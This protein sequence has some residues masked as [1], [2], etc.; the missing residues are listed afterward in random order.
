MTLQRQKVQIPVAVGI[1][2]K[3]DPKQLQ[4]QLLQLQNGY[5]QRT[6]EIRKRNGFKA[7]PVVDSDG[8]AIGTAEQIVNYIGELLLINRT[9]LYTYG[10]D[11]W[12]LK[13]ECLSTEAD[14]DDVIINSYTQTIPDL[15]EIDGVAVFAWEDSRGGSRAQIVNAYTGA[16]VEADYLLNAS[17]TRPRCFA[18]GHY[19]YVFY[20]VTGTV[21]ARRADARAGQGFGSE[22]T[23][24]S[25]L[26]STTPFYDICAAGSRMFM[27]YQN[28]SN[29]LVIQYVNQDLTLGGILN[30]V[31]DPLAITAESA[32]A[33]I[34]VFSGTDSIGSMVYHVVWLNTVDGVKHMAFNADF[35]TYLA[36]VVM[37]ATTTI[38]NVTGIV[39]DGLVDVYWEIDAAIDMNNRVEYAVLTES[40]NTVT[41]AATVLQRAAGLVAKCFT[42]DGLR[43][44]VAVVFDSVSGLQNTI[45]V[46]NR[47]G[48]IEAKLLPQIAGDVTAKT[49][50][51]SNSWTFRDRWYWAAQRRTRVFADDGT[52]FISTGVVAAHVDYQSVRVGLPVSIGNTLLIPGGYVKS[53]DG[54]SVTEQNFHLY[55][56]QPTG[57]IGSAGNIADGVYLYIIVYEWIDG[58][59][60]LVRSETSVPYSMTMTGGP[61]EISLSIPTLRYTSKTQV[62]IS[63]YRT[64][65]GASSLFYKVTSDTAPTYN[66]T[67]ADTVTFVDN[68]SDASLVSRQL[69][70][71]TGGVLDNAP[72]PPCT[73]L[74]V[75]K[76]R[77]FAGGLEDDNTVAY[78]K[79]FVPGD[80]PAFAE[81]FSFQVDSK[82]FAV[83]AIAEMDDKVIVFKR[84]ALFAVTG[85]GPTDT[86]TGDDF[87]VT[88]IPGD[89]GCAEPESIAETPLG[90]LFKSS[91]GIYLL[92]RDLSLSYIGAE[93]EAF[94]GYDITSAVLVSDLNQ[95]RFTTSEG[96]TLV[97]DYYFRIWYTFTGLPAVSATMYQNAIT[98]PTYY[99]A[100]SDGEVRYE[101]QTD[102]SDVGTPIS[103]RITTGWISLGG[104]Q[105]YQRIYSLLVLG[106][107]MGDH[108]L[109]ASMSYNFRESSNEIFTF[110]VARSPYG[111]GTYGDDY[112][113]GGQDMGY[114]Y[115]IK[116]Q[117]QK[118]ESFRL[119]LYDTYPSGEGTEG[120]RLSG[121]AATMGVKDS[122]YKLPDSRAMTG[123]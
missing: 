96:T 78:S 43:S 47:G 66:S 59:G 98:P 35:S 112:Y 72:A 97:Y 50:A 17:A 52:F 15:A 41:T 83:S 92:S 91:K 40:S 63:V 75:A 14:T 76:N 69:L 4:A 109:V 115:E 11:Q 87:Q 74:K 64:E 37:T 110:V 45:F 62:I 123:S 57:T 79:V 34:T 118:C 99:Y 26:E 101:S 7:L 44:S 71:T 38:R 5:V 30:G 114:Q 68:I 21:Y 108:T 28:T 29:D 9:S 116:P 119:T 32:D 90:L 24:V 51:L 103:T 58:K 122:N 88:A 89:V 84:S 55:P 85:N 111:T 113:G 65:A 20:V 36:S 102:Y 81:S 1:N 56:E 67:S 104:L 18:I 107:Y 86:G 19:L 54:Q 77:V 80:S 16:V 100:R 10:S 25:D 82:G 3:A 60:Q 13:D 53:Y 39:I 2:T 27:A 94:N 23:I 121:F 31:P 49:S 117:L 22:I 8:D 42:S 95:V 73:V 61:K 33:A 70:Y 120:F 48:G 93:V 46:V 6:G 12:I 105:G 106:E